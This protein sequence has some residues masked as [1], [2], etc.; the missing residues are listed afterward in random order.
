MNPTDTPQTGVVGVTCA[1]CGKT[2]IIIN[3]AAYDGDPAFCRACLALPEATAEAMI[4]AR[5]AAA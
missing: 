3:R 1:C 2:V 5:E 4:L